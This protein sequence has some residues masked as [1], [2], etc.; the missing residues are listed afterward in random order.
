MSPR[1]FSRRL[2][3]EQ[4]ESRDVPSV[5][6]LTETNGAPLLTD[7]NI[8]NDKPIYLP[9]SVSNTP[10]GAVS[11]AVSS[12]N[13]NVSA[14]LLTGG[15]SITFTVTDGTTVNGSF[16]IR[17]FEN[18]APL[19]TARLIELADSNFYDGKTF[20]R[21]LN[22]FVIQGGSP[23]GDGIGGSPLPDY[24]DEYNAAFTFSSPGIVALANAGDDG[25]D[26]QFFIADP[27]L[28]LEGA[29][30]NRPQFLNFNHSVVG[31]LT[32]G[33]DVY[34]AIT[35][36]PVVS[37]GSGEQSRP[38][39]PITITDAV[40]FTDAANAVLALTPTTGFAGPANITVTPSDGDGASAAVSFAV[41]GV[42]DNSNSRAFLGEIPQNLTVAAGQSV[43]FTVPV[44]DIDGDSTVLSVRDPMFAN[45]PEN[46]TIAIDQATRQVTLTPDADFVGTLDLKVGVR[47]GIN[48]A[49][50][51]DV[52]APGNFDTQAFSVNVTPATTEP[53][54]NPPSTPDPTLPVPTPTDPPP[55][56][57]TDPAVPTPPTTN[58]GTPVGPV[59]PVVI[60]ATGSGPGAAPLV[61]VLNEDGTTR[62][63]I[64]PFE[65][66]FTGGVRVAVADVTGDGQDDVIVVTGS[67][68]A[69]VLK[70]YDGATGDEL[71]S[72]MIFEESFRGGL[73]V[74]VADIFGL[75][76]SQII[77]G[78]GN[79]GGPRVT[80]FDA[81]EG[82]VLLNFFAHDETLRGGVDIEVGDLIGTGTIYIVTGQGPS[83]PPE[84]AGFDG[85]TGNEVGRFLAG[86]AADVR[87]VDVR[88]GDPDPETSQR[89]IF[90]APADG[91]G[92]E[93]AF[94]PLEVFDPSALLGIQVG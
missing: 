82:T 56:T 81:V 62:F 2:G 27:D 68:G 18:V 40:V 43:T 93:Q 90:V 53:V 3:C 92:S 44:T 58:G 91:S 33:F 11:Y 66:T 63:E 26:S 13:A 85:T 54:P 15:R 45:L 23:N 51:S 86:D 88:L 21:V 60:S 35:Q 36:V 52:N 41:T 50:G 28:P 34:Q 8:P 31:I 30:V 80:V 1:R 78:A 5:T 94:N 59:A 7:Q 9:L 19:A 89:Q 74:Q 87:G 84:V 73:N 48:R 24:D 57:P 72:E 4:L 46:V 42:V 17:L 22:D 20:H 71:L 32:D 67:G 83:G 37:N 39:T 76:Y 55:T 14:Q 64:T 79:T 47:D 70:V 38:V 77:I 29:S 69:P 61:T 6:L 75:G 16:T 12:D 25:N 49:G 65:D 10:N